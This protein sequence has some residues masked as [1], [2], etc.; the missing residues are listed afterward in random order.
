M[1]GLLLSSYVIRVMQTTGTMREYIVTRAR[2]VQ[3]NCID[4]LAATPSALPDGVVSHGRAI[5]GNRRRREP[6]ARAPTAQ[7]VV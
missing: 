7:N 6:E 1:H 3:R 4:S 2:L 5:A